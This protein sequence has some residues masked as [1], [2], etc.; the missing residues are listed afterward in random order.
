MLRSISLKCGLK[1]VSFKKDKI[2]YKKVWKCK[3]YRKPLVQSPSE[4]NK[5]SG[6]F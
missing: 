4:I 6:L 1:N 5:L 3:H 2:V